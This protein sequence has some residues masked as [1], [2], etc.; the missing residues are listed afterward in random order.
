LPGY[1]TLSQAAFPVGIQ[2]LA[3]LPLGLSGEFY[4]CLMVAADQK[5]VF[6][7]DERALLNELAADL[8]FG[9]HTMRV[10]ADRI[11]NQALVEQSNAELAAAYDATLA[12]WSRALELREHETAGHS[13]RVVETFLQLAT[14]FNVPEQDII[15]IRRGALLHD[16][17]KMGIPDHILLKAGPLS[18][19]EWAIMH[20]HPNYAQK[21]L[22]GIDYLA[23][24][25]EIPLCHHEWWDGS[26]YPQGLRGEEIPL[27]ARVFAIVDVWD[28]LTSDRPYRQ[29]WPLEKVRAY[30]TEKSG[31]QFDPQVVKAF[32]TY[33]DKHSQ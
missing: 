14:M 1:E 24:A 13:N 19:E 11:H 15:H 12:G 21:L 16:I 31:S 4:G 29:A 6:D 5:G 25:L 32:F 23:P 8:S 26:G 2:K 17:G 22:G 10:R 30:I 33:L 7:D 3:F 27:M 20:Q 28:A 9:I 18:E